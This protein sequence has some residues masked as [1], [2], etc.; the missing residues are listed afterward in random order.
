MCIK[1][2]IIKTFLCELIKSNHSPIYEL[3]TLNEID[4]RLAS[5]G[6]PHQPGRSSNPWFKDSRSNSCAANPEMA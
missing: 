4:S 5:R 2:Y 3:S 1:G 6:S